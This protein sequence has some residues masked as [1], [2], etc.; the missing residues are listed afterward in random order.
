MELMSARNPDGADGGLRM[1]TISECPPL[2]R[3]DE[4]SLPSGKVVQRLPSPQIGEPVNDYNERLHKSKDFDMD[5][6]YQKPSFAPQLS[7][8]DIDQQN[9]KKQVAL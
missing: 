1:S 3:P 8:R 7:H 4:F 5:R 9:F 6:Y 2:V